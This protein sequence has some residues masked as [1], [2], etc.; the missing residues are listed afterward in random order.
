MSNELPR[1]KHRRIGDFVCGDQ[2]TQPE[3]G[4]TES[5]ARNCFSDAKHRTIKPVFFN[6]F[7]F[8]ENFQ[9]YRNRFTLIEFLIAVMMIAIL[10]CLFLPVLSKVRGTVC[11]AHSGMCMHHPLTVMRKVCK[12]I[13]LEGLKR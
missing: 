1:R 10:V 3:C 7:I 8:L 9:V 11:M 5:P 2:L 6:E 12:R 4:R 13:I